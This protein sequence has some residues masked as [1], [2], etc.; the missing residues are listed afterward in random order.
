M[1]TIAYF[2]HGR[3]R[4]HATRSLPVIERLQSA[5]YRV[6]IFAGGDAMSVLD[7][8]GAVPIASVRP[9][10]FAL[11]HTLRKIPEHRERIRKAGAELLVTD[12]DSPSLFAA[13]SLGLP[14][15]A[16]GH[17]LLFRYARVEG[18]AFWDQRIESVN[19]A[20]S[21]LQASAKVAVHFLACE[22][23]DACTRI[24]RA[25]MSD[26][27][28]AVFQRR[29]A[30]RVRVI[31][32]FRDGNGESILRALLAA[33]AEV[34]NFAAG[35]EPVQGVRQEV[36][37]RARFL[38][39]LSDADAV[40][41]SSGCNL[42]SEAIALRKPILAAF[43]SGDRE[44]R[45][46]AQM[47][48]GANLGIASEVSVITPALTSSFC[49]RVQHGDFAEFALLDRLAP[50]SQHVLAAAQELLPRA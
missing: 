19:A 31:C 40:A 20:S 17:G 49:Q 48:Q 47:V 30:S 36:P 38:E 33:G 44:Q 43:R 10:P 24:A 5:G 25:D 7:T 23:Q 12:G 3:G 11:Y 21:S 41:C 14:S 15:I 35:T 26:L 9:G 32:Y 46:N 50:V 29:P 42:L 1:S 28:K 13:H 16:V 34:T 37:S 18:L 6:A 27:P 4:G 2:I 8:S 45:M 22:P 39:A